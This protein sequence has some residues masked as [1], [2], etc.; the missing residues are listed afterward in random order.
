MADGAPRDPLARQRRHPLRAPADLARHLLWNKLGLAF[1]ALFAVLVAGFVLL[2]TAGGFSLAN[3]AYLTGLDAAGAAVSDPGLSTPEK[4][5]AG[6]AHLRRAG[7]P[8]GA[9]GR[10]GRCPAD[11][12]AARARS[13]RSA[14]MSSSSGWGTSA[15]GSSASFTTS[16]SA[17]PAWT[18]ARHAAGVA[19]ARRLGLRVVIGETHREDMLRAAGHRHLPGPGLGDQQR[20]C[21]PG[22]R[23]ARPRP[24]QRHPDR[25]PARRRRPGRAGAAQRRQHHLP[26]RVL[27]RRARPSPRRCSSIRYCAPSRWAGTCCSSPTSGWAPAPSW[28]AGGAGGAPDRPGADAGRGAGRRRP[29]GLVPA[30]VRLLAPRTGS[31][32]SPPGR[33]CPGSW[34]AASLPR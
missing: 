25:A 10:G 18:R 16:A 1:G 13:A 11:R 24:G 28:T 3:A 32:S 23:A 6:P 5:R 9:H 15:P 27:P 33:G 4:T 31:T 34:P 14:S 12:I 8:A 22:D 26:Q 21:Q 29:G 20:Q 17:W 7:I 30:Q 2:A 19:M